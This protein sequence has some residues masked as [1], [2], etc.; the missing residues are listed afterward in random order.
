MRARTNIIT[1]GV[2]TFSGLALGLLMGCLVT[3]PREGHCYYND[4][5]ATC[6]ERYPGEA[7]YCNT[8]VHTPAKDGCVADRPEDDAC[9]SPCGGETRLED[10]VT[11]LDSHGTGS[12]STSDDGSTLDTDGSATGTDTMDPSESSTT[13]AMPCTENEECTDPA[14]P[15]CEPVSGECV[16]CAA[17]DDPDGACAGLDPGAPLCV[18]G[19]CVQ[20]T[21]ENPA[22]CDEQLLLCDDASNTCVGCVAHDECASG[23]CELAV[24]TCFPPGEVV[25]VDGD[26]GQDFTTVAAA[27]AS[28]GAGLHGVIVVH[29][30]DSGLGYPGTMVD[31]GKTIALLAAAGETPSLQ[32]TGAN[33]GLRIAGAGTAAY[34]DGLEVSNAAAVGVITDGALAWIDRSRI[35]GNDGGG[36]LA[37]NGAELTLRN[38]FVGGSIDTSVLDIQGATASVL[39]TTLGASLG[40]TTSITC[41]ASGMASV[42]NSLVVSR[43]DDD[44]VTCANLDA[45]YTAAEMMLGGTGNVALGAMQTTWFMS[46]N[47]GDFH[48]TTAPVSIATT[49]QWE[50]GDPAVD[51][52]GDDR[53][54]TDGASDFAGA[55]RP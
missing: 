36:V 15:F 1:R 31:Q 17:T 27:V 32:G 55:D 7:M 46:F 2:A 5:D 19:A 50:A 51:I 18:G 8:C 49:A 33:P 41:N 26:G 40:A 10:D 21:A 47:G 54:N 52:D 29:E 12:T 37:Q 14:A 43:S 45:S 3:G 23:G 53:P 6:A 22:A 34:V 25:H 24:G 13:G 35:V 16:T 11:C 9:Y 28:V 39:Y 42:R 38:C 4:G 30:Q 48:L 44:E 20:C